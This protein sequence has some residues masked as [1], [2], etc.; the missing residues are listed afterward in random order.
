MDLR[1][2]TGVSSVQDGGL[3]LAGGSWLA[4]DEV[5]T[6]IG[7]RPRLDWLDGSG[8]HTETGVLTD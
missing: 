7:A 8:V 1:L 6:A 5:V 3:A 4:A 2:A